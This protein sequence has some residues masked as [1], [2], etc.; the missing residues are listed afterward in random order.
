MYVRCLH[1]ERKIDSYRSWEII[2]DTASR[3]DFKTSLFRSNSFKIINQPSNYKN[4]GVHCKHN[5]SLMQGWNVSMKS[6]LI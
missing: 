3:P 4:R 2:E 1:E 6:T 5:I